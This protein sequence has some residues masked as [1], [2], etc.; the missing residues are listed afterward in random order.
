MNVSIAKAAQILGVSITTLRRW[1]VEGKLKAERTPAGH[2]RYD[3]AKLQRL[4]G[5]PI[6]ER[7]VGETTAVYARVM[8]VSEAN[9]LDE[10]LQRLAAYCQERGWK[11]LVFSDT[12][13][14]ENGR[15]PGLVSLIKAICAYK[16]DRVVLSSHDRLSR[17]GLEML[18]TLCGECGVELIIL[19]PPTA[20]SRPAQ[21]IEPIVAQIL[22]QQ[23]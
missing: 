8:D 23:A 12:A 5:Q 22:A 3:L 15:L 1:D 16:L 17:S 14:A 9:Q 2:R 21:A 18:L 10:Q 13:S 7:K 4:V 11:P 20:N 6:E 19:A